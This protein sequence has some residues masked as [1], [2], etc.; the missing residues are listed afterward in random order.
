MKTS[1]ILCTIIVVALGVFLVMMSGCAKPD[2]GKVPITT[3]SKQ[4]RMLYLQG[5]D[6]AESLQGQE[7]RTFFE[8]AVEKDHDFAMA[9]MQLAFVQPSAKEFFESLD[10]AVALLENVS[11]GE[12]LWIQGVDAGVNGFAMK[13]REYYQKLIEAYPNDER[14]YNLLGNSYFGQQDYEAAIEQYNKAVEIAPNFSQP[15]NQLGYAYR[16]LG[17]FDEA[18][19]A[20]KKYIELIPNDPNPYD[21]YAELMMKMGRFD[22]SIS[23]YKEALT[24]NPHF[25]ASYIGIAT[26]L[27]LKG[28]HQEARDILQELFD[29]ARDNG[30]RR[31][32][33]FA[34]TVSLVD[35]GNLEKALEVQDQ[36]HDLAQQ[37]SDPS[38]MAGDLVTKG[39]ILLEI[40]RADE[41]LD[42][43]KAAVELVENSDLSE[44]VKNNTRRA[45]LYNAARAAIVHNDVETA[46]NKV[47]EY[48]AA[49]T[50]INNPFQIRLAHEVA[51]MIALAEGNYDV[52]IDELQQANQQNPYNLY[53]MA[54]AYQGIGDDENA[55]NFCERAAHAN[56]LNNIN[57]AFCRSKALKM[58]DGME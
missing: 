43:Y 36:Q 33:L 46:H 51:G 2:S 49:V 48:M 58:L 6:L 18:E 4:A 20:F 7:A 10:R 41:A 28:K 21:S 23:S 14:A 53:R 50:E 38:A 25:V 13:Q 31:A 15:Y 5:R 40:G 39:N 35:E 45:F 37:I 3:K 19:Q 1:H 29:N 34:M 27:V 16:F 57:Y 9:H 54:L 22:E 56:S 17:N 55:K 47:D 44:D 52:A 11:E 32:A 30:E 8:Q 24:Q 42:M 12:R 26:N